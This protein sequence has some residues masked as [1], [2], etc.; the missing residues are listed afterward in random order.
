MGSNLREIL[1]NVCYPE[2]FLSFLTDKEKKN[3]VKRKC[4][5]GVLPTICLCRRGSGIF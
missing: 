2:I 1:E 4:H 5:F 3:R